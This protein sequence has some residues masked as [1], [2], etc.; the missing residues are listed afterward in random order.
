MRAWGLAFVPVVAACGLGLAG[1]G[2][3]EG[4]APATSS[5]DATADVTV[6]SAEAGAA[7]GESGAIEDAAAEVQDFD[8]PVAPPPPDAGPSGLSCPDASHVSSCD[9]CNGAPLQCGNACVADCSG[10]CPSAPEKCDS[11]IG[12]RAFCQ[13][14]SGLDSCCA[15]HSG[16]PCQGDYDVCLTGLANIH[17]CAVCGEIG[18]L[19][20]TCKNGKT[21]T[22]SS[23]KFAC[24]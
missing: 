12:Q 24:N 15:L 9:Q 22:T 8:A 16:C 4:V 3:D 1:T 2:A 13:N 6:A 10:A 20:N 14:L 11:C 18:T 23:G 17:Y 7:G 5:A 21:C 19:F